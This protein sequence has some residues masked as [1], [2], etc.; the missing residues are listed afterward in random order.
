[1]PLKP[2]NLEPNWPAMFDLA[3]TQV[4]VV[5]DK[6]DMRDFIVEMLEF[7]KRLEE[8]ENGIKGSSLNSFSESLRSEKE[9]REN[10]NKEKLN[11]VHS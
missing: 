10:P 4:K 5:V 9:V 3:V 2:I 6:D 11:A 1:M 8:K 7:G